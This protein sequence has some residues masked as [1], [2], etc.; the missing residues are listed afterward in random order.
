MTEAQSK[1]RA[2]AERIHQWAVRVAR[3]CRTLPSSDEGR[4]VSGQLFR[5][6]TSTAANYRAACLARSRAE[7]A[8]KIGLSLEECDESAFWLQL[9]KDIE[10][11]TDNTELEWLVNEAMQIRFILY[12]SRETAR[13][14]V[15]N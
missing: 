14:P 10:L 9:A 2:L 12:A 1:A 7:F 8:A 4:W 6:S 11:T 13:R 5:A 15:T 3:F